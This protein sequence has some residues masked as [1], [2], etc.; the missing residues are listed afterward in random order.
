MPCAD[1]AA[2]AVEVGTYTTHEREKPP[3]EWTGEDMEEGWAGNG[4]EV[5]TPGDE[6]APKDNAGMPKKEKV[7]SV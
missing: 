2:E 1:T 6:E 7:F 3:E 5:D 4:E